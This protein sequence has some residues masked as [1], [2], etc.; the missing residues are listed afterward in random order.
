MQQVKRKLLFPQN[1]KTAQ[2]LPLL[3]HRSLQSQNQ[4]TSPQPMTQA[5]VYQ[6]HQHVPPM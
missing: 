5:K 1:R 6:L 3:T 2:I 4:T